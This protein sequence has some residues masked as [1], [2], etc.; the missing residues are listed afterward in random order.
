LDVISAE[1]DL[2]RAQV[3]RLNAIL[4]YNRALATLQRA[5]SNLS[6][7]KPISTPK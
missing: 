1:N 5:V 7:S 3:N 6:E 4:N 2:T